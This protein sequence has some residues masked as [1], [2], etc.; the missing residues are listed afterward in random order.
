MNLLNTITDNCNDFDD[1]CLQI[2]PCLPKMLQRFGH[3]LSQS[4]KLLY[5][6]TGVTFITP[7]C[8]NLESN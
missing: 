4:L 2:H 8:L 6:L 7:Y 3:K 1:N 5:R